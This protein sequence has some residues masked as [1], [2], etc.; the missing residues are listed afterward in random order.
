MP[1]PPREAVTAHSQCW[2]G[3]LFYLNPFLADLFRARGVVSP[4]SALP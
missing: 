2:M 3:G 1:P 4:M